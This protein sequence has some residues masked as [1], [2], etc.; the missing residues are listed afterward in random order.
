MVRHCLGRLLSLAVMVHCCPSSLFIRCCSSRWRGPWFLYEKRKGGREGS[1]IAHL[2]IVHHSWLSC[3]VCCLL[4]CC[5]RCGPASFVKKGKGGGGEGSHVAN[6][7]IAP[8]SCV[9]KW[10]GRGVIL[11]TCLL[12]VI[13][14]CRSSLSCVVVVHPL[15][16]ATLPASCVNKG[17]GDRR[18]LPGLMWTVTVWRTWHVCWCARLSSTYTVETAYADGLVIWHCHIGVVIGM[19]SGGCVWLNDDCEVVVIGGRGDAASCEGGWWWWLRKGLFVDEM[20]VMF[21]ANATDATQYSSL[22]KW[23]IM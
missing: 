6:L 8:A 23:F 3:V 5:R 12:S 17:E 10:E 9:N 15:L 1:N 11:L 2:D 7:N 14:F 21:L 22:L 20:H 16:V 18:H 19:R 4:R 13:V